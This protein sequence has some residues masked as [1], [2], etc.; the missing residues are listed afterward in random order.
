[1]TLGTEDVIPSTGAAIELLKNTS[2][3]SFFTSSSPLQSQ[4]LPLISKVSSNP[5]TTE[6]NKIS[7][8]RPKSAKKLRDI[9]QSIKTGDDNVISAFQEMVKRVE[10]L[11]LELKVPH[12]DRIFYNNSL[13]KG[14]PSSLEQCQE[15]SRY[16]LTLKT[17][18]NHILAVM[19]AIEIRED[20]I[21]N[22]QNILHIIY[23]NSSKNVDKK[24]LNSNINL[25]KNNGDTSFESLQDIANM[26]DIDILED[27]K[28]FKPYGKDSNLYQKVFIE[29]LREIQVYIYIYIYT[30]IYIYIFINKY[31]YH[32]YV[33]IHIIYRYKYMYIYI[34]TYI[35][36][37]M[38]IQLASLDVI[39]LIQL[40]RRNMW[41]PNPIIYQKE[42]W[43]YGYVYLDICICICKHVR[44]CMYIYKDICI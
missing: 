44:V 25:Y 29:A 7:D 5:I 38:Y 33:Y 31:K 15:L 27:D 9:P 13:L 30:H 14:P 28:V 2:W 10:A 43:L 8:H 18:R 19:R 41:R 40:C 39:R 20:T 6:L 12:E 32:L 36:T 4:G 24:N 35:H 37:Y 23:N 3:R 16:L 17:H 1:M 21:S 42:G 11:W 22:C 26:N 34:H